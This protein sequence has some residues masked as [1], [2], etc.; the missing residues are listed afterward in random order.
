[1][2]YIKQVITLQCGAPSL[3]YCTLRKKAFLSTS[4]WARREYIWKLIE[5]ESLLIYFEN[6]QANS[7]SH[8]YNKRPALENAHTLV[9]WTD[10]FSCK[11]FVIVS[12][13]LGNSFTV[14]CLCKFN[15]ICLCFIQISIQSPAKLLFLF[16]KSS[17]FEVIPGVLGCSVNLNIT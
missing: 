1:M 2:S 16:R 7:C 6:F 10:I 9:Q 3:H 17:F 13:I 15:H 14:P 4:V 11:V 5:K 8:R 12:L